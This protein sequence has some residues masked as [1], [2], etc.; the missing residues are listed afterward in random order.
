MS[1]YLFKTKFCSLA[2]ASLAVL[3]ASWL[4]LCCAPPNAL[5]F[6]VSLTRRS[7]IS[8]WGFLP[9]HIS[10]GDVIWSSQSFLN[11]MLVIVIYIYF[12][13]FY[14]FLIRSSIST[15]FSWSKIE[16][17][18]RLQT[19]EPSLM[20]QWWRTR[21]NEHFLRANIIRQLA[22]IS[23]AKASEHPRSCISSHAVSFNMGSF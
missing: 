12:F 1:H 5:F 19:G 22:T 23:V 10:P 6:N 2:Q 8:V 7:V 16:C 17:R 18:H 20:D 13:F 21:L 4:L 11:K 15:S 9:F 14:I 3:A